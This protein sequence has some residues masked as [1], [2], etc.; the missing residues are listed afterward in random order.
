VHCLREDKVKAL[1]S[2]AS[3]R[4]RALGCCIPGSVLLIRSSHGRRCPLCGCR[5]AAFLAPAPMQRAFLGLLVRFRAVLIAVPA[6]GFRVTLHL[7]AISLAVRF[8]ACFFFQCGLALALCCPIRP[9]RRTITI[10]VSKMHTIIGV[11]HAHTA[12]LLPSIGRKA[13]GS[14]AEHRGMDSR[15]YLCSR[16][17]ARLGCSLGPQAVRGRPYRLPSSSPP[18]F[19]GVSLASS[20]SLD[21]IPLL[22]NSR[23]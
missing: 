12:W 7:H 2:G 11:Q 23:L 13:Q 5:F 21:S 20:P 15:P 8:R 6:T 4:V 3:N 10:V 1:G 16:L 22:H 19:T 9:A 14:S 18:Q 17:S